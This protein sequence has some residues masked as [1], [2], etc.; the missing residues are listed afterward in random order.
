MLFQNQT[1]WR[2]DLLFLSF[3]TQQH[4]EWRWVEGLGRSQI[5]WLFYRNRARK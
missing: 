1:P 3:W 4:G 2:I 5:F